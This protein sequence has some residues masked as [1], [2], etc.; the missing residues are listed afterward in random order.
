MGVNEPQVAPKAVLVISTTKEN[1]MNW[2]HDELGDLLEP[3]TEAHGYFSTEIYV[4]DNVSAPLHTP[5]NKGH[6]AMAYLTYIIDQYHTLPPI[7]IFIHGHLLAWHNNIMLNSNTSSMLRHLRLDKIHQDGYFNLRCHFN[8]GCPEHLFPFSTV[9]HTEKSEEP[10]V[11]E[12]WKQVFE[13]VANDA[14][15]EALYVP[16]VLAQPCCSQFAVTATR[17]RAVPREKY[18]H[19]RNWILE[20]A[21]TDYMS[22]RI[23]EYFWQ[24]IFNGT[25]VFCPDPRVCYCEGYGICFEGPEEYD[26]WMKLKKVWEGY[27]KELRE[28]REW[29]EEREKNEKEKEQNQNQNQN[30]NQG[31]EGEGGDYDGDD[32]TMEQEN[33]SLSPPPLLPPPYQTSNPSPLYPEEEEEEANPFL[34]PL[35]P[36]ASKSKKSDQP[37]LE[38]GLWLISQMDSIQAELDRRIAD[39]MAIGADP[40]RRLAAIRASDEL[41]AS[42]KGESWS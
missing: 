19:F 31:G 28:W 29:K 32:H 30:Q 17:I 14:E 23:F 9:P 40:Q 36:P 18:R 8:P 4:T 13:I 25:A 41:P 15:A 35:G 2:L 6:E 26:A 22:G 39:A 5:A 33:P 3:T 10:F 27:E 16:R 12:A 37:P 24:W 42:E 7:S 20:T 34:P 1:D 21:L 11:K 38:L